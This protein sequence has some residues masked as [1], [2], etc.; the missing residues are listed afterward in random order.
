M[1]GGRLEGQGQDLMESRELHLPKFLLGNTMRNIGTNIKWALVGLGHFT[2]RSRKYHSNYKFRIET[3]GYLWS[4][5]HPHSTRLNIHIALA[6]SD[7][8]KPPSVHV[9]HIGIRSLQHLLDLLGLPTTDG[10]AKLH[11]RRP[12]I[13]LGGVF[14]VSTGPTDHSSLI[15]SRS[16]SMGPVFYFPNLIIYFQMGSIKLLYCLMGQ[17]L[18]RSIRRP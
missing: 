10:L 2:Y 3:H 5:E 15:Q 18:L 8:L 9:I 6:C 4:A 11:M 1:V 13:H 7:Q 16:R 17:L 12:L 14:C